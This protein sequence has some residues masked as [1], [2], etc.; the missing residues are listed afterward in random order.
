MIS[1]TAIPFWAIG[2]RHIPAISVCS[3]LAGACALNSALV[4]LRAGN[5]ATLRKLERLEMLAGLGELALLLA[6]ARHAGPLGKP[7]FAGRQ[8]R[9]L[10]AFT[11]AGGIVLPAALNIL[12]LH[13]RWKTFATSG[14][15]LVG[16]YILREAFIEGGKASADDP[17]AASRQP[18]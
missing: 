15:T 18:E 10:R 13:G 1:A 11:M 9:K 17:R 14:L 12:P 8:G 2:K 7:M 6:F 16:G 3:G 5:A 4:A